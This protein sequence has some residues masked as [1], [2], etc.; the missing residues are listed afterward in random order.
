MDILTDYYSILGLSFFSSIDDVQN[1]YK[2]L[3][4]KSDIDSWSEGKK[5]SLYQAYSLLTDP[6]S[7]ENYDTFHRNAQIDKR[8]IIVDD[9]GII[10]KKKLVKKYLDDLNSV[11]ESRGQNITH[12]IKLTLDEVYHGCQKTFSITCAVPCRPCS[13]VCHRCHGN[14]KIHVQRRIERGLVHRSEEVCWKCEGRGYMPMLKRP[15]YI[16]CK[17]CSGSGIVYYH[18]IVSRRNKERRSMACQV[19]E[20]KGQL[21]LEN[22]T[23]SNCQGVA[24]KIWKKSVTINFPPGIY[25]GYK[26]LVRN[27]GQHLLDGLP[28]HYIFEVDAESEDVL[29]RRQNEH[30]YVVLPIPLIKTLTGSR[31]NIKVPSGLIEIDTRTFGEIVAPGKTYVVTGRGLPKCDHD[32]LKG[33]GYG[34]VFINFRIIYPKIIHDMYQN[35]VEK[36]A[37]L[38][39]LYVDIFYETSTG[40][41]L[42]LDTSKV[43]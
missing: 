13:A 10:F 5:R 38:E 17:R 27:Y 8:D 32:T 28:G 6:I 7:K 25:S 4:K 23:C 43:F 42:M 40:E 15:I 22:K 33:G 14:G 34:D 36:L 26:V 9:N 20:G 19:C 16:Q 35:N 21:H 1:S 29:I 24:H 30:L 2:K 11:K 37:D 31:Y 39:R 12:H 18:K 41:E 3:I